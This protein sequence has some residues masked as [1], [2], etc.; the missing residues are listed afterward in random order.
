MTL[1]SSQRLSHSDTKAARH[2]GSNRAAHKASRLAAFFRWLTSQHDL[3]KFSPHKRRDRAD[4]K[5]FESC[6]LRLATRKSNPIYS[7]AMM[8]CVCV[9]R[10]LP[11]EPLTFQKIAALARAIFPGKNER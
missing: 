5:I 11:V 6:V 7:Q 1:R 9:V 10:R 3:L 8:S 2:S 4:A